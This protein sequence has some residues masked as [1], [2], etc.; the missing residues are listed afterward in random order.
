MSIH[1]DTS[2][3]LHLPYLQHFANT[4]RP[5]PKR[6][7]PIPSYPTKLNEIPP[8]L[9]HRCTSLS[10]LQFRQPLCLFCSNFHRHRHP[11]FLSA[12]PPKYTPDSAL[13]R[14]ISPHRCDFRQCCL[15]LFRQY[16]STDKFLPQ[17]LVPLMPLPQNQQ[18]FPPPPRILNI[19]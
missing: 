1:C 8:I 11:S 19:H 10:V 7:L 12:Y 16:V 17:R 3:I 15:C 13:N 18:A 5:P 6:Q 9:F 2:V 14:C 4:A